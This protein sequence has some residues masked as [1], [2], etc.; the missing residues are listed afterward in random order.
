[1]NRTKLA[2]L[3][4][5]VAIF[6]VVAEATHVPPGSEPV[7]YDG[8]LAS[9]TPI[10]GAIGWTDPKDGYDWYCMT[11]VK[12]QKV[13]ISAK[14]TSGNIKLNIGVLEGVTAKDGDTVSTLK[15]VG[16]TSN[17]TT[18]DQTFTFT[19]TFDGPATV[20]IST[21]LGEDG[22]NYTV[23]MTGAAPPPSSCGSAPV[24]PAGPSGPSSNIV[25]TVP[26]DPV[27]GTS[28]TSTV[29]PISV[30]TQNAFADDVNLS[31]TGLPGSATATFDKNSFAKPG[32]GNANLTISGN[33][34]VL[35][36][37]YF[38]T[39]V[40]S[41]ANGTDVGASTFQFVIDC[42]PPYILGI[43]QPKGA[44]VSN[45]STASLNV[46]ADGTGPLT[47]QWY[48][49]IPGVT[50][51][52]VANGNAAKL[53][54]AAITGSHTFWVRVSNACGTVDSQP[55]TVNGK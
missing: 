49:G 40:A 31:V 29:V 55:A 54:T 8:A 41:A 22:G 25:V 52:P 20:W 32:S 16:E 27:L 15:I 17:S 21:W 3:A 38:V 34:E 5:S 26:T 14:R 33:G 23:T 35:P 18:P 37:T 36:G 10:N 44:N 43:N 13:A 19:P 7:Q 24:T 46:G 9:G 30:A 28:G 12:G 39:V 48:E 42:T 45:G 4:L 1:M 47:Y 51:S 2:L 53:T 6:P 50:T 11:V